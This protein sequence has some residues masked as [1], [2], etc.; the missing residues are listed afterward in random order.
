M[1]RIIILCR[2]EATSQHTVAVQPVTGFPS[3]VGVQAQ[4]IATLNHTTCFYVHVHFKSPY[5]SDTV[6]CMTY[7]LTCTLNVPGVPCHWIQKQVDVSPC[8][9]TRCLSGEMF[10]LCFC[11][12]NLLYSWAIQIF[13][14]SHL[15]VTY[16]LSR[17]TLQLWLKSI[18]E[19]V[20]S[21]LTWRPAIWQE[22]VLPKNGEI[23]L[24]LATNCWYVVKCDSQQQNWSNNKS[25][26]WNILVYLTPVAG[27]NLLGEK[28][29]HSPNFSWEIS[30]LG[31]LK[32]LDIHFTVFIPWG[33]GVDS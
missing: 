4:N 17:V 2:K 9:V 12:S 27:S 20:C 18:S 26:W 21:N 33:C 19:A 7:S 31:N 24:L 3:H 1:H 5:Y 25:R 10:L 11:S 15:T 16:F 32:S 14:P 28:K 22:D 8:G 13:F 6:T 30:N 29:F 23:A